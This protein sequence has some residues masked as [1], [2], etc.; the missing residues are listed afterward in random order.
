MERKT[1]KLQL[2]KV[3]M[4]QFNNNK[5]FLFIHKNFFL[6]EQTLAKYE[7]REKNLS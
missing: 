2:G 4:S 6:V 7:L 1:H 3:E 5:H